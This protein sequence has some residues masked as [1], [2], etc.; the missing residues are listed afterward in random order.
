MTEQEKKCAWEYMNDAYG[1]SYW[2][3]G[4][5]ESFVF[6]HDE[7]ESR[8]FGQF[9]YCPY[10]GGLIVDSKDIKKVKQCYQK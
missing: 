8:E 1:G 5:G 7:G 9:K 3:T 6:L 10:C 4:C 2:E